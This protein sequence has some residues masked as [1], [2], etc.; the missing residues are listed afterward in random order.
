L[1]PLR[2]I[3]FNFAVL[4]SG[5]VLQAV[6]HK[7]LI[8]P[9][10][11]ENVS[12]LHIYGTKDVLVNNDETLYL[13]AAFENARI[14]SHPGGHFAP[15]LWPVANI[16]QFLLEQQKTL[17]NRRGSVP[18]AD[19]NHFQ[20]LATFREKIE[21][22][23]LFHQKRMLTLPAVQRKWKKFSV[24]PV[25]L[26]NPIVE[27]NIETIIENLDNYLFDDVMLLVWCE[28]TTFHNRESK[29]DD[30]KGITPPFFRHWIQLYLKKPDQ[31]LSAHLSTIRIYGD[32]G[33]LKTIYKCAGQ[34]ASVFPT[35]I[36]LLENLKKA[37]VKMMGDQLKYDHRVVLKPIDEYSN[38]EEE[39]MVIK[40][41]DWI[42]NCA[43]EAPRISNNYKK[44]TTSKDFHLFSSSSRLH[45]HFLFS[46]GKRN[47]S[48]S[49]AI[50]RHHY[51]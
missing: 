18:S 36:T 12:S 6:W 17:S 49:T 21:A 27:K 44:S 28:R 15:N 14:V 46:Y 20:S 34:M 16:K 38:A 10:S 9:N 19:I 8:Q 37:C 11:I 39:Q 13:A 48:V 2:N 42:S 33:D 25:G 3:S 23:I 1:Q 24:T 26:S 30:D 22:T 32:W 45:Y 51:L 29:N 4:I 47:C 50:I 43:N 41:N 5:F 40:T 31:V 7:D 35:E